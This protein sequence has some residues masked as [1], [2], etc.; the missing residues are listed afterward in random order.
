MTQRE[1]TPAD[2]MAMFRRRWVMIA[3]LTVIGGPIA[4]GVALMLPAKYKSQTTVLVQPPAVSSDIVKPVDTTDLGQRLS[5]MQ[6]QILSRSRLEPIIRQFGL[7]PKEIDRK[8]MEDLVAKLQKDIEVSPIQ[9]MAETRAQNLPGFFVA[10]SLGDA[11]TAQQVCTAVTSMFIAESLRIH[12]QNAEDATEFL[13]QRL[14]DAKANLD[15]QDRK[16]AV[17]KSAHSGSLPDDEKTNL[18]LLTNFASQLDA[19]TQALERAQ[20]DKSF[21]QSMLTQQVS[22]WQASQGGHDP[23]TMEA[24]LAALQAQL[25]ALE[26]KYTDDHPDVIKAKNDIAALQQKIAENQSAKPGGESK[27]AKSAM[28]PAAISQLRA[29]IHT[30]D[31]IIAEKTK[32]EEQIKHQINTY[33]ARIQSSPV[34]EQQY[35]ELTRGYQTAQDYYSD[36]LKKRDDASMAARLAQAQEGEQFSVLDPANLPDK[37]SFPNRW[38]FTGGGIGGGL[39]LGLGIALLLEMKDTSLRTER[40]VEF[41]LHLPMLAMIP[42]IDPLAATQG[43]PRLGPAPPPQLTQASRS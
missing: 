20:Q 33:Q 21:A 27:S 14:A 9:P 16:L 17:F 38:L 4:F 12:T 3:A 8:P 26:S 25:T 19:A 36:L 15:E 34:V 10:V 6:Q 39:A 31:S 29:Q 18:D 5:S 7:F 23:E 24:Q 37:P 35:K 42:A 40:D 43:R 13:T 28:E 22:A 30:F 11:R 41:A 2:Y 1:L 32:D